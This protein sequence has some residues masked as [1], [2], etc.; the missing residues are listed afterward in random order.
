MFI[1]GFEGNFGT[2]PFDGLPDLK[3]WVWKAIMGKLALMLSFTTKPK[4]SRPD[5]STCQCSLQDDG[6]A[7]LSWTVVGDEHA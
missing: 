6:H 2:D 5:A 4:A 7:S 1:T 3:K